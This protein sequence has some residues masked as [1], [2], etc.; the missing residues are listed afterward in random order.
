MSELAVINTNDYATMAKMMGVAYDTNKE[1]STLARLKVNKAPIMG[2]TEVNGK[3]AKVEILP[4]G[5]FEI[6][7]GSTVYAETVIIRPFI[8]RFMYQK[9]D[10]NAKN[11]VKTLM[12]DSFSVDLKDSDG[13]FNC[14]KPSG[15]IEDFK[16]LPQATQDLLRSIQRSRVI[17]G[18]L[19]MPDAI[20]AEGDAHPIENMPFIWDVNNKEGYKNIGSVFSKLNSMK[21]LPMQHTI[22]IRNDRREVPQTYYVPVPELDTQNSIEIST[23]DQDLFTSFM[24]HIESHNS[25]VL[26]EYA[27]RNKPDEA[28]ILDNDYI[29]VEDVEEAQ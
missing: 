20:T 5:S 11:Y 6:Q 15:Y 18:E 19:S 13:G 28:D 16:A 29:D 21:R 7:N 10:S 23:A 25:W 8:Q 9:Y 2:E 27:K 24:E 26:S 3:M 17:F 4:G 1:K 22:T 12:S 14:G